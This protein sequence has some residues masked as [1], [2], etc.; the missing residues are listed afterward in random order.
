MRGGRPGREHVFDTMEAL[1]TFLVRM[2]RPCTWEELI[3][4]LGGR[5]RDAYTEAFYAVLNHIYENYAHCIN[6]ITRWRGHMRTWA[7]AIHDVGAPAPRCV[8]FIDGT[9]R[10]CARPT[11]GQR[12]AYSGH[13][14]LHGIKFQSV[15]APNGLIVDFY[16]CVVGRRADGYLLTR[17]KFVKRMR[18]LC[19]LEGRP[20]YV[21]G[22]PAYCLSQYI[23]RGYK[24]A[25]TRDQAEFSAAMNRVRVTVEWGFALIV[26]DWKFV[27]Y[28]QS[29]RLLQQPVIHWPVLLPSPHGK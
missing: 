28:R 26:R 6:D 1:V 19:R 8:G 10:A 3:P 13:K 24:G 4:Y 9:F 29:M 12:Q 17:S 5:C 14:K 11:R 15:V 7:D 20:Y 23:L 22:D 18:R 27:D 2:A 25:C 16:G 21:Y